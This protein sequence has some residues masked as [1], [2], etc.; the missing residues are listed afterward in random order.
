MI[1]NFN[2]LFIGIGAIT[3]IFGGKVFADADVAANLKPNDASAAEVADANNDNG[4]QL[5]SY[6]DLPVLQVSTL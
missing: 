5:Q 1:F 6:D 3:I 2:K 4:R